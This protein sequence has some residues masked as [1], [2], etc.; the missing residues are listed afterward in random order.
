MPRFHLSSLFLA[1]LLMSSFISDSW[2]MTLR[3]R[4]CIVKR[5][6]N[7][8]VRMSCIYGVLGHMREGRYIDDLEQAIHGQRRVI[9]LSVAQCNNKTENV[10]SVQC[11][12]TSALIMC[13]RMEG[14]AMKL[15]D[16][17]AKRRGQGG[18]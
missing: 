11:E 8:M 6:A 16:S 4:V 7:S 18:A 1:M 17:G 9:W 5:S 12:L 14:G 2:R 15:C 10:S 13:E 3:R